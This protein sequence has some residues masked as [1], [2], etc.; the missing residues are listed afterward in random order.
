MLRG[1]GL[2][3][4]WTW[5]TKIKD[6]VIILYYAWKNPNTPNYIRG[7]LVLMSAYVISPIDIVPDYLPFIGVADD[8][9]LIPIGILSLTQLLPER[10]RLEC[11]QESKKWRKR[12]PLLLGLIGIVGIVWIILALVGIGYIVLKLVNPT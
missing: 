6:D 10:V 12:V 9:T 2:L 8:L 1:G 5:L 3:R 7:L 11:E 4:T